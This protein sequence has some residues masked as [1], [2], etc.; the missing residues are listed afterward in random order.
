[1]DIFKRRG[2]SREDI[3]LVF[4]ACVFPVF[5]WSFYNLLNVVPAFVLR[6]NVSE[7]IGT[8]AY[9]LAYALV[10]SI[11]FF[12]ALFIIMFLLAL[13]L[14]KKLWGDHFVAIGSMLAILISAVAMYVQLNYDRVLKL[15]LKR[16]LFDLGLVGLA[17]VI[18]YVLILTFPRFESAIRSVVRGVSVLSIVYAFLGCLSI[19]IIFFR[20]I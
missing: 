4:A 6:L 20:N 9:V 17:F 15:S 5:I 10:E 11:L 19:L 18:Y 8:S 13:I 7:L 14:P 3:L 16:T 12:L 1:L 2:I